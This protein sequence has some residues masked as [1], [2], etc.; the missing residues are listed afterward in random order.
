MIG[1]HDVGRGEKQAWAAPLE[2]D[3]TL[4]WFA[5]TKFGV[6]A[7]VYGVETEETATDIVSDC[8]RRMGK[9]I[10][11]VTRD[12]IE[13]LIAEAVTQ[14][15]FTVPNK[16]GYFHDMYA[17]LRSLSEDTA[18]RAAVTKPV[19][20]A[21]GDG[22]GSTHFAGAAVARDAEF[23]A[24]GALF[25]FF[26]LVEHL[27]VIG[28]AFTEC[29]PLHEPFGEFLRMSWGEKFKRVVGLDEKDDKL[30]YDTL[31]LLA[32]ENRNPSAHG[33]VD[34]NVANVHVHLMGYG[35]VPTGVTSTSQRPTY[36]FEPELPQSVFPFAEYNFFGGSAD[37][38]KAVDEVLAWMRLGP[39]ADAFTYGESTLPMWFDSDS[40]RALRAAAAAGELEKYM[41][42][43]SFMIDQASNMDW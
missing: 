26:S 35:A 9:A 2:M 5:F 12:L 29:D 1:G 13:P 34:R 25:A 23:E 37:G 8:M 3:G 24:V 14:G 40:R 10:P 43:R 11:V 22:A 15:A 4:L 42:R 7:T 36:T 33:G 30:I 20:K 31:R 27:L 16:F 17:H 28:L 18:A 32:D 21:H 19:H 38:W 6:S 39:L 41:D